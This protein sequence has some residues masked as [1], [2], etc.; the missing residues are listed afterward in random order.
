MDIVLSEK[1]RA[2]LETEAS[3]RG[4]SP[5]ELLRL[6]VSKQKNRKTNGSNGRKSNGWCSRRREYLTPEG[7]VACEQPLPKPSVRRRKKD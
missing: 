7:K 5:E 1:E 2:N 3:R 4:L 6:L